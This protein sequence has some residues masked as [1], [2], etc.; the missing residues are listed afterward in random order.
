[1][2]SL[3]YIILVAICLI[4]KASATPIQYQGIYE[5]QQGQ[6]YRHHPILLRHTRSPQGNIDFGYKQDQ[7][8]R[9]GSVKLDQNIYSSDDGR[10]SI[11]V[12]AQGNRNFDYNQNSF[13]GGIRG[14]W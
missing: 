4:L 9:E 2:F 11:D 13:S 14:S 10:G 12:Y 8:G 5:P 6:F 3:K 7:N 1:M